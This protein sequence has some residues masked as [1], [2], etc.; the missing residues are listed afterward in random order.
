MNLS[1]L[2]DAMQIASATACQADVIVTR[3]TSDFARSRIPVM[4]P[5]DFVQQS[6]SATP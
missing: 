6:G 1:D 3:N 4:T 5:E 2:E